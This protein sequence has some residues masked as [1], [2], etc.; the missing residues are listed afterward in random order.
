[1]TLLWWVS[2][3]A[4]TAVHCSCCG[5]IQLLMDKSAASRCT[6]ADQGPHGAS[7]MLS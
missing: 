4:L 3:A 6:D 1:M 2:A 7:D 5:H